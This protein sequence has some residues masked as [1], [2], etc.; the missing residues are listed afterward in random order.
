MSVIK[1]RYF[2]DKEFASKEAMFADFR[3]NYNDLISF[4]KADIQKSCDKGLAITCRSLDLLKLQDSVKGLKIDPAYYYIAANTT[5]ILDSH[6]DLHIDGLWNKS[7]KEQQGLNYLVADHE[8]TIADTIVRKEHVEMLIVKMPFALLGMPYAG[9]TEVLVYKVAKDKIIH[10]KAKEWLESGD[11]IEASVR[12]QYVTILF[13]MDSNNPEDATLKKNYDDYIG[14]IANKD[15]FE[16]IAYFFIVK[17]A[18]NV[19][20]ASLVIAGSNPV[21]GNLN[22][23]TEPEKSTLENEPPLEHSKSVWDDYITPQKEKTIFHYLN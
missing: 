7:V 9:E 4:K 13:A 19:R 11:Q 10:A 14:M 8:L 1:S 18:K 5:K 6:E 15:D 2:P 12:M 3:A 20:E 23:T 17:E 16:Y 21:T 22:R